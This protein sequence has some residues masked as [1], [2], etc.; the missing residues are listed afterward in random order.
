MQYFEWKMENLLGRA[1][2]DLDWPEKWKFLI[3]ID[4]SFP[5]F[6][7]QD[8][9]VGNAPPRFGFNQQRLLNGRPCLLLAG[10]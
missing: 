7:R 6:G 5:L 2:L 8:G 4:A 3:F 1:I 9:I 10:N